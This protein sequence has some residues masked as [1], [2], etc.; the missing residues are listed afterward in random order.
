MP[1]MALTPE[2]AARLADL[3]REEAARAKRFTTYTAGIKTLLAYPN[4][5]EQNREAA[6]QKLRDTTFPSD[7]QR[8]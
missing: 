3:N 4:L 1:A 5:S 6:L 8:R 2:V 7:E